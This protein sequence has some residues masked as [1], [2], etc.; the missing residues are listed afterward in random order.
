MFLLLAFANANAQS[1][2]YNELKK[3]ASDMIYD[4]AHTSLSHFNLLKPE[5]VS[6]VFGNPRAERSFKEYV[7]NKQELINAL[8]D[9]KKEGIEAGLDWDDVTITDIRYRGEYDSDWGPNTEELLGYIYVT[10]HGKPF[11]IF[12]KRCFMYL[13]RLSGSRKSL[14]S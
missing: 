2:E 8:A 4:V 1:D 3:A 7:S 14:Y 10:S 12:F 11:R 6:L 9:K 13:Y 5:E